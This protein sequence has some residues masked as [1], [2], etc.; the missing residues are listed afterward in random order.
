MGVVSRFAIPLL[1]E[2]FCVT[3]T[4][5]LYLPYTRKVVRYPLF[6]LFAAASAVVGFSSIAK[7]G[8]GPCAFR[9]SLECTLIQGGYSGRDYAVI[10]R[11]LNFG[12]RIAQKYLAHTEEVTEGRF[13]VLPESA[14]PLR[15]IEDSEI[16]KKMKDI[17]RQRNQYIIAGILLEENG[18]VYNASA[19]IEPEGSLQNIY[20]KRN[21]VLFVETSTF[22]P[23]IMADT[24]SVDGYT[25]APVICYESLFFRSYFRNTKPDLY[26]VLSNDTFAD[27][28]ILSHLHIAYGVINARALGTPLLQAMQNGPSVYLDSQGR[29]TFL[30]KPYEQVIGLQVKIK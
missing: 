5:M 18:N 11:H 17:A 16:M 8:L 10:D 15:Q 19:L 28:T 26:I 25:I 27:K 13:L 12:I 9:P 1:W 20:R 21:Q 30:T 23:G 3:C 24:F 7:P 4:A 2:A 29:L 22:T 6:Q 14:F